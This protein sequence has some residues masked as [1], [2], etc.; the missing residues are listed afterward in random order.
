MNR[1][2]FLERG[3][4]A[5]GGLVYG[6]PLV[7]GCTVTRDSTIKS[8]EWLWFDTGLPRSTMNNATGKERTIKN[9]SN[10]IFPLVRI[11]D[12]TDRCGCCV[13]MGRK[14]E[15]ID[16]SL[17]MKFVNSLSSL[18]GERVRDPSHIW[19]RLIND[20][21]PITVLNLVDIALWDL[22]GN[23]KEQPVCDLIGK[24][25]RDSV[26]FYVSTFPDH[27]SVDDYV[28]YARTVKNRGYRGLKIHPYVQYNPIAHRR[29]QRSD[30]RGF[31]EQDLDIYRTVREVLGDGYPIIADNAQTYTYEQ[32]ERI[33]HELDALSFTWMES[34]MPEDE[35]WL[36]AYIRLRSSIKTPVCGPETISGSLDA[37]VKWMQKNA[38]DINRI[39][40]DHGGF[41]ACLKLAEICKKAAMPLDLHGIPMSIYHTPLYAIFDENIL[42]WRETHVISTQPHTPQSSYSV[43]ESPRGKPWI[44]RYP[45]PHADIHGNCR[46]DCPI[47]GMGIEYNW[48]YIE[49]EQIHDSIS[50]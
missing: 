9:S 23:T 43:I 49:Q 27:G 40:A 19:Q 4:A 47:T 24:R 8:M 39:D 31:P 10:P 13:G 17:I 37:R 22:L 38:V 30:P 6:L 28:A 50:I 32:A 25:V 44:K 15:K 16:R 5:I 21:I 12:S 20:T 14:Y 45:S 34:P 46:V 1:K 11:F 48:T 33:G 41:T 2:A 18:K 26:P 29:R 42:P 7:Q 3:L 35:K 36:H